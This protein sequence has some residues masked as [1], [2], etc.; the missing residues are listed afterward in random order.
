MK[1]N[2]ILVLCMA[3]FALV[4]CGGKK[5]TMTLTVHLDDQNYEGKY[6]YV[7]GNMGAYADSAV[8]TNGE[9]IFRTVVDEPFM[10]AVFTQ[11]SYYSSR[12]IAENGEIYLD[13]FSDSLSGTPL[14]NALGQFQHNARLIEFQHQL[15]E[16]YASWRQA[17]D[18]EVKKAVEAAFDSVEAVYMSESKSLSEA[19][20]AEHENDILGAYLVSVMLENI[21]SLA[22]AEKL[23]EGKSAT[24]RNYQPVQARMEVLQTLAKTSAGTRFADIKGTSYLTGEETTLAAM[25]EGK[26]ALVDFWASWCGPC[27][28]EI[29]ENLVRIHK[30]Y[31]PKGL[32]VVGIDVNDDPAKHKKVT[33]ELGIQYNQLIDNVDKNACEIYGINGIPHIML[34]DKDG[35]ILARNLRGDAIEAAVKEALAK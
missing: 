30:T 14:N 27:R 32:V 5:Q 24:V 25:I 23:L 29:K 11:P 9:A 1:L 19:L 17:E 3:L 22:E 34:V 6:I 31:A 21:E 26:V 2:K 10:M 18:P 12:C 4:A 33:D 16:L 7:S 13:I 20:L 8:I 28:Q 15:D 35:T